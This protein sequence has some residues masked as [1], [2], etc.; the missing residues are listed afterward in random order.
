MRRTDAIAVPVDSEAGRRPWLARRVLLGVTGGVAAYKSVQVARDLT[1]LGAEVD[2]VLSAA[3]R[4]FVTPLSFEAVTGRRALTELF[5]AE[6][7]ARHL[8]LGS[9]ADAVCV[10]PA[11]ADFLGRMAAGRADDLLTTSLLAVR[12]PILLFPAMNTLMLEHPRVAANLEKLR[13]TSGVEICGP[14][15]GR[16][17]AGEGEGAGRML[18]PDEIT[19]LVGRALGSARLGALASRKVL[20]TAGPTRE[21]VD[22]VRYL[23][24]RSSG[25]MGYALAESAWLR[26]ADVVLVT[27]PSELSVPDGIAVR[28]CE[29]AREMRDRVV[30]IAPDRDLCIFAAAVADLR[31]R[32]TAER[33]LKRRD[34][35]EEV[36]LELAPNPDVALAAVQAMGNEGFS[37]GFALESENMLENARAKLVGGRFDMVVANPAG[38]PD[39]GFG[40]TTNRV[41]VLRPGREPEKLPLMEKTRV[42]D[43]ILD[44]IETALERR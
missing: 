30:E 32:Q 38:D 6:G 2:V 12:A 5:S 4:R 35:P 17:A 25:R 42:A 1:L 9:D 28:R 26:G 43:A 11:T 40:A 19:A 44:R 10:A 18:E 21:P 22:T 31:P 27:G 23:G 16:L 36:F 24:N 15:V 41:T 39:A 7:A 8:R 20:V 34:L 3:A 14:G 33:K 29:T 37:V 13:G